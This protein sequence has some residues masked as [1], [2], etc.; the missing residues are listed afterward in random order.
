MTQIQL[1]EPVGTF[2]YF[3]VGTCVLAFIGKKFPYFAK[4][5]GDIMQEHLA[6]KTIIVFAWVALFLAFLCAVRN[7]AKPSAYGVLG[8]YLILAPTN[9]II[10]LTFVAAAI[11]WAVALSIYFLYPKIARGEHFVIAANNSFEIS[12][13]AL[14]VAVGTWALHQSPDVVKTV[15][16]FGCWRKSTFW[17]AFGVSTIFWLPFLF[18]LL[19]KATET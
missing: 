18:V 2:L 4:D 1:R 7:I 5:I 3:F 17:I 12:L 8:R 10:T 15:E 11:N 9:F 19:R 14:V 6:G 16:P 13:I